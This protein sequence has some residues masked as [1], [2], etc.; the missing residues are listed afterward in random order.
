[1]YKI[2]IFLNDKI[3]YINEVLNK[4]NS[5]VFNELNNILKSIENIVDNIIINREISNIDK[6]KEEINNVFESRKIR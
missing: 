1:M 6:T 4:S 3:D 5:N 2:P